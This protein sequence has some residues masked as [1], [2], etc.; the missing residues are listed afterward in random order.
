MKKIDDE[1]HQY[2]DPYGY[3]FEDRRDYWEDDNNFTAALI[4]LSAC[5]TIGFLCGLGVGYW[6][7]A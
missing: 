2:S 6:I 5:L 4:V 3:E 7:W 1:S